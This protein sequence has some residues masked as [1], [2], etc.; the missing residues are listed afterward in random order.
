MDDEAENAGFTSQEHVQYLKDRGAQQR[1]QFFL[2]KGKATN[3]C[4]W[5]SELENEIR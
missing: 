5:P 3:E 4:E 2:T 1:N